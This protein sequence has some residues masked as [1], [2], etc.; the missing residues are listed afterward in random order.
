LFFLDISPI[1]FSIGSL[2]VYWYGIIYSIS[3]LISWKFAWY[4]FKNTRYTASKAEFE[5]FMF[6]CI[7]ACIIGARLGHVLFFELEYYITHPMEI[8]MIRKGGLS[9]HG[10]A[11]GIF[12]VIYNFCKKNG[13]SFK[14]LIDILSFAGAIGIAFGRIANFINQELYGVATSVEWAVIFNLVDQMPRHPSQLYESLFEGF[15][16]FWIMLI[17]WKMKG[18]KSIGSGLYSFLFMIIYSSSRYIIEFFKEVEVLT[19]FGVFLFTVGQI[20]SIILFI[21]AF[22]VLKNS[23]RSEN[24]HSRL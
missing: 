11:L 18:P 23:G 9:F 19:V 8:I 3:I 14:T 2:P 20:L 21:A 17:F 24:N 1:A 5:K 10:G 6:Q 13:Y 4:I 7:I 12:I 16:S 22:F 15:F